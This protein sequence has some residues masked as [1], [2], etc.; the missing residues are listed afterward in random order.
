MKEAQE[1]HGASLGT[2]ITSLSSAIKHELG[3]QVRALAD[4][5]RVVLE[6]APSGEDFNNGLLSP[7]VEWKGL[8]M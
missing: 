7:R 6:I 4:Q 8:K 1:T 5:N 3:T 2:N